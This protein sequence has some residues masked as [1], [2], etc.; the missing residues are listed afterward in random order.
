MHNSL[1]FC[2]L[3]ILSHFG[4]ST[5][6]KKLEILVLKSVTCKQRI[7]AKHPVNLEYSHEEYPLILQH[8]YRKEEFYGL[9]V[10]ENKKMKIILAKYGCQHCFH[11]LPSHIHIELHPFIWNDSKNTFTVNPNEKV[12]VQLNQLE[13]AVINYKY[14]EN[15]Y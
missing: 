10:Y 6:I 11:T 3:Y 5:A 4:S 12:S 14:L 15:Y 9:S 2:N 8:S 13:E 7:M 1:S